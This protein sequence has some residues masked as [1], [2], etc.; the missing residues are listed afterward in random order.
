MG[1]SLALEIRKELDQCLEEGGAE[2]R[3][4]GQVRNDGVWEV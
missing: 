1:K 4:P 3:V 2:G